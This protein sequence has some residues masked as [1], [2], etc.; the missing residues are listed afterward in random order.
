MSSAAFTQSLQRSYRMQSHGGRNER[1]KRDASISDPKVQH[2][3][4]VRTPG[5]Q[6]KEFCG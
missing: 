5:R 3:E 6:K 1:G 4:D 2:T